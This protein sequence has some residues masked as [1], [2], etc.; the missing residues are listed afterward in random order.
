MVLLPRQCRCSL[1]LRCFY[2][3]C[4]GSAY[5]MT[6]KSGQTSRLPWTTGHRVGQWQI[7]RLM[8]ELNCFNDITLFDG[9]CRFEDPAHQDCHWFHTMLAPNPPGPALCSIL[10]VIMSPPDRLCIPCLQVATAWTPSAI[11]SSDQ[12]TASPLALFVAPSDFMRRH[13]VKLGC[14]QDSRNSIWSRPPHP[15]TISDRLFP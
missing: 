12:A 11:S 6:L 9:A 15:I 2:E 1:V 8:S 3:R 10:C 4:E 13:I 7:H 14:F 5:L